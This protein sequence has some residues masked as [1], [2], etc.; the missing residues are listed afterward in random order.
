[1][2]SKPPRLSITFTPRA[3]KDLDNIWTWNAEDR[4]PEH[5][6]SYD[7]F[8]LKQIAKLKTDYPPRAFS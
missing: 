4:S 8:L 5:A 6:D 7:E 2:A 1:M 3:Q